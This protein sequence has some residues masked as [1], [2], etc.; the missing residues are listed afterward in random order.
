MVLY[1]IRESSDMFKENPGLWMNSSD[2][3]FIW[4]PIK[5]V[6]SGLAIHSALN[7]N[8]PEFI[9]WP[10]SVFPFLQVMLIVSGFLVENI[11]AFND[12]ICFQK[13]EFSVLI[14]TSHCCKI[15]IEGR[16]SIRNKQKVVVTISFIGWCFRKSCRRWFSGKYQ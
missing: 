9:T 12:R 14:L 15:F 10:Y 11:R 16:A 7:L 1:I 3:T 4:V 6:C 8:I 13:T 2:F 5:V